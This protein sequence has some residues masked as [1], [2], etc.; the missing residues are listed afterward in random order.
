MSP[1]TWIRFYISLKLTRKGKLQ[2]GKP[3]YNSFSKVSEISALKILCKF[4]TTS[5][6]ISNFVISLSN[7]ETLEKYDPTKDTILMTGSKSYF[8]NVVN[9][10]GCFVYK[11][12]V[13]VQQFSLKILIYYRYIKQWNDNISIILPLH[14]MVI[15]HICHMLLFLYIMQQRYICIIHFELHYVLLYKFLRLRKVDTLTKSKN[16]NSF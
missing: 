5:H 10:F 4:Q 12:L 15:H 14:S 16:K 3:N 11:W 13:T 1:M 2:T 9:P 6:S 8:K 7:D